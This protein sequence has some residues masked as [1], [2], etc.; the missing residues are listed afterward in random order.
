MS[1]RQRDLEVFD[2]MVRKG[3]VMYFKNP[4]QDLYVDADAT[5]QEIDRR[6]Q[7]EIDKHAP[8][9]WYAESPTGYVTIK[10]D[11]QEA[12]RKSVRVVAPEIAW[13]VDMDWAD[14]LFEN[15][16]PQRLPYPEMWVEYAITSPDDDSLP[17]T[18]VGAYLTGSEETGVA[19]PPTEDGG[20]V[21]AAMFFVGT[22]TGIACM[23]IGTM[24]HVDAQGELMR[25]DVVDYEYTLQIEQRRSRENEEPPVV[26]GRRE[27][28]GLVLAYLV[29]ATI[30]LMNCKN[31]TTER[32][33]R[34]ARKLKKSRRQ[35]ADRLDYH[36][37][38]LPGSRGGSDGS[39]NGLDTRGLHKV[40]GHFK[41]FTAEKPLLGKHTGT[42]W[43]GWQAR[44]NKR[45][46]EV[47]SDYRVEDNSGR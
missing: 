18:W 44:G 35:R 39:A 9:S 41:H 6:L 13:P 23:D 5:D 43:W 25:I 45:Y 47:K 20:S 27:T 11:F 3:A 34:P 26:T 1:T 24:T 32:H 17:P 36:T 19:L 7:E 40:R 22:G 42:Y 33:E 10:P 30:G 38:V 15:V 12:L 14:N 46:G 21:F 28:E 2:N 8:A 31:V 37:V 29:H 16:G 4:S